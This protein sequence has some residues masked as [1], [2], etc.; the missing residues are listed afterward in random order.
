[1]PLRPYHQPLRNTGFGQVPSPA[2]PPR[3][4]RSRAAPGPPARP[5]WSTLRPAA[6]RENSVPQT[7]SCY[8]RARVQQP[9]EWHRRPARHTPR[10][11]GR[12]IVHGL[13]AWSW[14]TTQLLRNTRNR[15]FVGLGQLV[16]AHGGP[17]RRS[18]QP[19]STS[20]TGSQDARQAGTL[21]QNN[22]IG[23][24]AADA[25]HGPGYAQIQPPGGIDQAGIP[26]W[27]ARAIS[28]DAMSA[29]GGTR[30]RHDGK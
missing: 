3:D 2:G 8:R 24:S 1:M 5:R 18:R 14:S 12:Y 16:H 20:S 7:R 11:S 9:G 21:P 28:R 10:P 4:L 25:P 19:T 23:D 15:V 17:A 29:W 6:R 27:S 30:R 13:P 26:P 22:Q